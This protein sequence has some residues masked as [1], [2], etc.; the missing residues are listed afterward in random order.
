M[1]GPRKMRIA[2]V[3]FGDYRE[4][5]LR[6]KA[7]GKETYYAQKYSV[8]FVEGLSR[9]AEFVGVCA[10]LGDAA[11]E[12]P[13]AERL[14]SA[15]V[16]LRRGALQEA[17]IEAR[18]AVWAPS[19]LIL[20]I[21][22]AR[23]IRWAFRRG[24]E[25][26]PVFADS[27][28]S[29]GPRTRL[30]GLWM[31]LALRDRRISVVANHNI[32]ASLSLRRIGTPADKIVPWDWPHAVTPDQ[33]PPKTLEAGP[34]RLVYVGQIVEMKGCAE[35][36]EAVAA[37]N[38]RGVDARLTLIGAG[39]FEAGAAALIARLGLSD[40][41]TLAGKLPH[42]R[43]LAHLQSATISLAPSRHIYSEG[44]PMTIYEALATRTPIV[45]SDH[46]MFKHFFSDAIAARMV[47][48]RDPEA[49]A[50]A[51]AA[52]ACDPEAY[53]A[54]SAATAALWSRIKCD[55]TWGALI[56]TWLADPKGAR[57]ALKDRTLAAL[58]P[59]AR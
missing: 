51:I 6:L 47:P 14:H 48:E 34:V 42:D 45:L 57:A 24:V 54:A 50:E 23:L 13:V 31:G 10:M 8:D 41:V 44:L 28:E 56:E 40:R 37:L 4:A 38:R 39:D 25:V 58:A 19:H 32:P 26:L 35:A 36:I 12:A 11:Y 27:W 2:I 18:L 17:A 3:Q 43:V 5:Y 33:R 9:R 52:L 20:Q 55:L 29:G 22:N 59:D 15:C 30:R 46:P 1:E 7:T 21:P 53:A 16:P 49:M